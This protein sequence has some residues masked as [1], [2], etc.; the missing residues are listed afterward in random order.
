MPAPAWEGRQAPEA[1]LL[2]RGT[3]VPLSPAN[4][5]FPQWLGRSNVNN[6]LFKN[7]TS[8]HTWKYDPAH[9]LSLYAH[10]PFPP[11]GEASKFVA[12]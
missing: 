4:S 6:F 5:S 3:T 10:P 7:E 9:L 1:A 2:S 8:V 11:L 12:V